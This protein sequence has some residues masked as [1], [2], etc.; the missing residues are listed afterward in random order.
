MIELISRESLGLIVVG[1]LFV[2][3]GVF[4]LWIQLSSNRELKAWLKERDLE[5]DGKGTVTGRVDG[6]RLEIHVSATDDEAKAYFYTARIEL[7]P[8]PGEREGEWLQFESQGSVFGGPKDYNTALEGVVHHA[9]LI[10]AEREK[11]NSAENG[12]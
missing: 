10:Q 5:I 1:A 3:L 6:M 4:L 9:M 8:R 2:P 12:A 7:P 11:R